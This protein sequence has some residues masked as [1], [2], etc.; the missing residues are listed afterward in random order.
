MFVEV[1]ESVGLRFIHANGAVGQY[2]LPEIMGSGGAFVDVDQ[3]GDL[4]IVVVQGAARVSGAT[5][6]PSLR[7]FRNDLQARDARTLHFTDAT[8]DSGFTPGG[9]GMG[10]A[11][12]DY[13]NDGYPDVY[14]TAVGANRLYHN[15]RSGRFEDVTGRS[16]AGLDDPRWSTSASFTDYDLDGDLDLYVAN[17]VDF[18]PGD[19]KVCHNPA[20]V[21]DYCGPLQYRPVPDR[22]F[23]N[24]GSGGFSDVTIHAGIDAADGAGLGVVGT[25]LNGDH[26]PDFY[27]ANDGTANQLWINRGDGRFEDQ[28]LISGVALT[29]DATPEGSMGIA[30]GDVDNDGDLDLF[31]TNITRETHAFYRNF[32][33]G[34]FEDARG[35]L[36]LGTPT[37]PYTGFGTGWFDYDGDGWL[38]LFTA[39]GAVTITEA[40]RGDTEPYR[41][42]N[43]LF[44]NRAGVRL[45]DVTAAAGEALA[46]IEVSRGASIGDVDN[47]GDLDILVTNNGGP[48]RLL[49]NDTPQATPSLLVQLI[50]RDDNR[51]GVGA[52]VSLLG[53]AR[54]R[55]RHVHTDGS[56]LS[57]GDVRVHLPLDRAGPPLG[58]VVEWPRGRRERWDDVPN[59]GLLRLRQGSGTP[60]P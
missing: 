49:R 11:I 25:D 22:L 29:M 23:R 58:I 55:W 54:E 36:G 52:R 38:D 1:A 21:R 6:E 8:I 37:A 18:S 41:Q 13:D 46:L 16:G 17:Y 43:Q 51:Q 40:V 45:E 3:D 10:L 12:G 14:L 15:M 39:N 2:Q 60:L 34:R 9:H 50:G 20:G 53:G 27:V 28:A 35:P 48:V 32:G 31:V 42:R 33:R 56:Y 26:L 57:G 30:P 19:A 59:G 47:D 7:L 5:S 44:R 4:D 24:D